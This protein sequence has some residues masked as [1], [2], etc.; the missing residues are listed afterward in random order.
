MLYV[1]V[2]MMLK[3]LDSLHIHHTNVYIVIHTTKLLIVFG[4]GCNLVAGSENL[5]QHFVGFQQH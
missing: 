4:L 2:C 1:W 5:K 3:L